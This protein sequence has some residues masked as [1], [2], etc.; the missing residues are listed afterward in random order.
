MSDYQGNI[1]IKNPATPTGPSAYGSAP[2][3]WK[4]NEVAYWI[5]QGVWP[6]PAITPDQYFPY[7]SLLLSTTSLGNA[8]NNLFV[9]SSGAFNPVSRNGNTTQGSFTPYATNW[10]NYF[11]GSG[12]YFT[13]PYTAANFD[14]FTSG[15]DFTIE[16]WFF[17]NSSTGI[18]YSD[19]G[20]NHSTVVGNRSATSTTDYWSFGPTSAGTVTFYYYNG[21]GN[22]VTSTA[23]YSLNTW[24]HVAMTKTSSGITIF[25]NGVAGTTTAISGSPSTNNGTGLTIGQGNNSSFNGYIS[26]LRIVRGTAIYSGNFTVPTAPLT[27]VT[28]TTLLTCQSNRFR[29]ASTNNLTLTVTGNT[30]VQDFSPFSPAYPG[31]VYNQSDITNW[32]GYFDGSG[33]YLT[34]PYTTALQLPGDFT[35]ETWVYLNSRVTSFPC[36]VANYSTY[37]TNG[38]F[39]LFAGHNFNTTKYTVSFN[40]SFPVL[41]SSSSIVYGAWTHLAVVRSGSTLTLY[42]NGTSEA[43]ATNSAT[44]TGTGDNWWIATSGDSTASSY[45]NGY[46]SN[47]RVVKGTAVYTSNFTPPTTNLTAISGTSLLTLQNAAFTDN[48]TNNFVI[49]QNGNPTVA[50]NS[51][52]NTVGYWSN[53]FDGSGDYLSVP[54]NAA[55]DCG[56]GD[57]TI[58]GWVNIATRTT[59]YPAFFSNNRGAFATTPPGLAI[60]VSNSDSASYND[61][62]VFAWGGGGFSSPSAG[63]AYLLVAN[64][65]NSVNTWYHLAVVRNGTSI[66]MYRN[67]TE[68]A[69]ATISSGSTFDWGYNG[70]LIGGGN[71]D[72][73]NSYMNGYVSNFRFVKGTAVY[74]A[75]FTPPTSPL[76][77]IS[78]T[79]LLT[80]QNGRYI[81]NSTNAFT[82]T[83][84]GDVTIQSFD[85]F[86]TSTIA[87][88]GGS[89]YFDGSGDYLASANNP[90]FQ[91]GTGDF[92]V[93]FW[94]YASASGSYTQ[95]IGTLL[96]GTEAG[97]WRIGNRFNSTNAVYFARGNGG[98]YDEFNA[99]INVND[100]AWHHVAVTRSS[101]TVRIFI[102]GVLGASS[103]I[104]GTC[105][106]SNDL[107]MGYNQRDNVYM[108]GYLSNVRIVK[109]TALYTAAFTPPT[110]PLTPTAATT[111][112][113][114]GMN[115]GIYDATTINDME[116]VGNA[117]VSTVQS[118]FGGSSVYFDGSG[119]S[120]R[121][122][123]NQPALQFGTSNFTAEG[124]VYST[125]GTGTYQH[126]LTGGTSWTTGS[127]GIY[128]YYNGGSPTL[129]A[130]W[131][132]IATNPAVNSGT[133]SINTWY[134]FAL[135]RNGNTM[136]LYI[137]GTSVSSISVTGVSLAFNNQSRTNI[138]GGGWDNDF[139][140]YIDDL[141][142]TNGV[143]RYTA[144][145]TPPTQ[146]FPIY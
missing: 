101:G 107:R 133:L 129:G 75:A 7:V 130:A 122:A 56:T 22:G 115:A 106:S 19:A 32:S 63:S 50:G 123:V 4:L 108:T 132:Q 127:G 128:W 81:D 90:S 27:A 62:F 11:D 48:S 113:V 126:I 114:N 131:N 120:G 17:A 64:A 34:V 57:W 9:D 42:V 80:C 86:Y 119:D 23:T 40:G 136:T 143:A 37:T 87:S 45:I 70:A 20:I 141:R 41:T 72:G 137:N 77:A 52:V 28:N 73:A 139:A 121:I 3:M 78:G 58:E 118:K 138:G 89:M 29:D 124:W 35:I 1:I 54:S 6:N 60:T 47:L 61:K 100:N 76:T 44:V 69:S 96:T 103:T 83:R 33:D 53:Y 16:Y 134:H 74:T 145:F 24:N 88:N 102:D 8:N 5:K 117:Q 99:A 79:S 66:K 12:D 10:S 43:T 71:W 51:P 36:I 109:G 104:S 95:T 30:S 68:V 49:T 105:T 39:A 65:T 2:G 142:V 140:G 13:L 111:L 59:N 25:V 92:T 125:G 135:V 112:L 116:T 82:V 144:N 146:P 94:I 18:S 110:A 55:F 91:F 15:T 85:P 97:T 21:G 46:V 93:E 98:G 26:N 67:G 84:N 38:G 14:W 31:I